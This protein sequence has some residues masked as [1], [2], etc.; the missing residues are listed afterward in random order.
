[1]ISCISNA[2]SFEVESSSQN[3]SVYS[4]CYPSGGCEVGGKDSSE[5]I[6]EVELRGLFALGTRLIALVASILCWTMLLRSL[7]R[8]LWGWER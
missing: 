8:L 7:Y 1:L 5:L 3:N 4:S 2:G 6:D